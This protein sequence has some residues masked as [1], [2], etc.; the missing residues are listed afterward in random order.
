MRRKER[1]LWAVLAATAMLCVLVP[2]AAGTS[3]G[4]TFDVNL[5]VSS[6]SGERNVITAIVVAMGVFKGNGRLVEVPNLPGDPD[7][8]ARDDLVFGAGTLHLVTTFVD[9]SGS[10]N[11]KSCRG[12]VTIRQTS[13]VVGG[14]GQFAAAGGSFNATLAGKASADRNA[15][16]SCAFDRGPRHEEDKIALVGTLTF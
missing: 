5:V 12:D 2:A 11:P 13:Q 8:V 7:D 16:G 1:A 15:D 3:V 6:A 9:F 10:V 14:T 4:E